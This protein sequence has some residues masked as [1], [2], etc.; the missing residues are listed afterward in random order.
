MVPWLRLERVLWII[1]EDVTCTFRNDLDLAGLNVVL[2]DD[3]VQSLCVTL[4]DF[5][6]Q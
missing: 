4:I 5:L 3:L 2:A 6:P 1:G